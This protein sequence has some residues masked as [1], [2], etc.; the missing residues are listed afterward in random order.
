M[1]RKKEGKEDVG[2]YRSL[3]GAVGLKETRKRNPTGDAEDRVASN[4]D[5]SDEKWS[6]FWFRG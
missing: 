2:V 1:S 4:G 6:I 3:G 5:R